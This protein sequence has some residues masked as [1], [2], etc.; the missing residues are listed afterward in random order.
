MTQQ[1]SD[2]SEEP[3]HHD[4]AHVAEREWFAVADGLL[5]L[6][7]QK[8]LVFGVPLAIAILAGALSFLIS[9]TY[10]ATAKVFPPQQSAT[11]ASLMIGQL[12][13]LTG[14][15]GGT[16]GGGAAALGLKNPSDVYV[17]MVKS[18]KVVDAVIK[19]FNLQQIYGAEVMTD[20]RRELEGNTTVSAGKDGV[21]SIEVQDGDAKRAAEIANGYIDALYQLTQELAVTEASQR[22]LFF[23]RQLN[24]A[25]QGL[26]KAEGAFQQMQE[27]TGLIKLEDQGRVIIEAV[28][29]A[30]A[31]VA[32]KEVQLSAMRLHSTPNSPDYLMAQQELRALR[33]Q[34]DQLEQR[35]ARGKGDVFLSTQRVPE[36]GLEYVRGFREVKYHEAMF[37]FLARQ[38]ELAKI[39][40]AKNAAMIQVLE[41][42]IEPERRSGPRRRLIVLVT[43]FVMLVL[44]ITAAFVREALANAMTDPRLAERFESLK[45]NLRWR[46]AWILG[47]RR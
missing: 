25:K 31:A 16:G 39:D 46:E 23:E 45:S 5:L 35:E 12:G 36:A 24:E 32:S 11:P 13:A 9:P 42:A 43:F 41:D 47:R 40:E 44:T 2:L 30:R 19:R 7:R 10:T 8:I 34:L 28:S 3:S 22:R 37:E 18:R 33:T 17:S 6:S 14:L 38:F 29:R 4:Q 21:I 20:A 15:A 1:S 27:K 26:T